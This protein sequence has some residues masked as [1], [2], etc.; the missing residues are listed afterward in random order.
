MNILKIQ[1]V[2]NLKRAFEA[3]LII[4]GIEEGQILWLGNKVQWANYQEYERV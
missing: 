3:G 4:S 2:K 1:S